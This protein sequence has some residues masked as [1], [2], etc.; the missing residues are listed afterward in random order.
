MPVSGMR[1]ESTRLLTGCSAGLAERT[2][3]IEIGY[4]GTLD[5]TSESRL[6]TGAA[7]LC[8][9]EKLFGITES[10]WPAAFLVDGEQSD[11][12]GDWVVALTVAVQRWAHDPVWHGRVVSA[13]PDR[14]TLAIPWHREPLFR[15]AVYL[16]LRLVE[17]WSQPT[18]NGDEL[19]TLI[20]YFRKGLP[21]A[22]YDGLSTNMLRYVEAA[23]VRGIPFDVLPSCVQ[24][25]WGAR[26]EVMDSS[27]TG[28]TSLIGSLTA[29][30]RI[31]TSRALT[32]ALVP[33]PDGRL[34]ADFE[35]AAN[36][37]GELGWPVVVKPVNSDR[38]IGGVAGI[39]DL[40]TLRRAFDAAATVNPGN[41]VVESHIAGDN[42][43]LLVVRGALLAATRGMPDGR[44]LDVTA[45]VHPD[46]RQL[47]ERVSRLVGL[48]I[49]A[50]ELMISDI[51]RSWRD[52][53]GAVCDVS[54]QPG[55]DR[56]WHADPD[57]DI[58]GEVIDVLFAG[59]SARIPT[60][61]ITGTDGKSTTATMLHHIWMT[62]G[63]RAGLCST[64]MLRIGE[65]VISTENLSG[66]PGGHIL[67]TDPGVEAA[68]IEMPRKGL[69]VFGHPCD[70]YD[71]AAL[72]NVGDDHI[73]VDGIANIEQMAELKAEV[74]QRARDAI[75]VNAEDPLT[76]AMRSRAGTD[77]H[78][79]VAR[80]PD[81]VAAHRR[82]GGEAVFLAERDGRSW[83]VIAVGDE[84]TD[85][86]PTHEI[87]ATMNGLLRFNETN[88]MFA[89]ALAWAQRIDTATIRQAL[90]GFHNSVAQ[91]PG[92]YNF[93]DGP[94]FQ[95]LLDY[96]HNLDE[97]TEVCRVVRGLPV[98]GRRIV[99]SAQLG[100]RHAAQ[101]SQLAPM[102]AATFDE[103]VLSCYPLYVMRSADYTGDDPV[104]AMLSRNRRLLLDEG[105]A[106]DRMTMVREPGPAVGA[107]L[108]IA[109]PGDL[110]VLLS[111]PAEAM[112]HLA[113]LTGPTRGY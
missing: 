73:G 112:P 25:G 10:D 54:V 74:L 23:A 82:G 55:L 29:V 104:G 60:A 41:V 76:M 27:M 8:P 106:P 52:V 111:E 84:E 37:A 33:T 24:L 42:H 18:P 107:A 7:A 28:R 34:V 12:V 81:A 47:A 22:Q 85:L 98:A 65:E 62:A 48:D 32:A 26:A 80:H 102:L 40:D 56:H 72:L 11:S 20:G 79:L 49:A 77:R 35:Q 78:I 9:E 1:V 66:Y 108:A 99:C 68:V 3:I 61:A 67:L 69:I 5:P 71:V 51:G 17:I 15:D 110:V 64:S 83:I 97:V 6:R 44:Q 113:A 93:I 95:V 70:R 19:E 103:F 101:F 43:Q 59:G 39:H 57:R 91:N 100:N 87:P 50:V 105:V 30:N 63:A 88:A 14:V 4:S 96:G 90:G 94:Q 86:I 31:A 53:G 38:G 92:R 46:N 21:S 89:A 2:A 109:R 13:G 36:V 75:V 16:A 58:N 45:A